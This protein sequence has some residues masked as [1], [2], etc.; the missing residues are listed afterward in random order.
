MLVCVENY[1]QLRSAFY[2]EHGRDVAVIITQSVKWI[3]N[4]GLVVMQNDLVEYYGTHVARS[5]YA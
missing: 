1:R 3:L 2:E 4:A 5:R